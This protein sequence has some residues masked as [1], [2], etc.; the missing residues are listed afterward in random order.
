MNP[1]PIAFERG[2]HGVTAIRSP[3]DP[4][5]VPVTRSDIPLGLY[6]RCRST[7]GDWQE[8]GNDDLEMRGGLEGESV[9]YALK[10]SHS[11][12]HVAQTFRSDGRVL[13]WEISIENT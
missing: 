7:G 6:L 13:D 9:A 4:F 1:N 12:L 5:G 2:D 3:E 10:D 8:I 11:L